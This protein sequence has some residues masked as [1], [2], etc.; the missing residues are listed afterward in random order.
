[1]APALLGVGEH[2]TIVKSQKKGS[3]FYSRFRTR[4][5]LWGCRDV[6]VMLYLVVEPRWLTWE[7]L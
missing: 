1:M 5:L 4:V 2:G 7:K 3:C 6:V